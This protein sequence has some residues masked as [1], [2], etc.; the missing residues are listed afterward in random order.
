MQDKTSICILCLKILFNKSIT[1][2]IE[3]LPI[4]TPR[5]Y[6]SIPINLSSTECSIQNAPRVSLLQ[7]SGVPATFRIDFFLMQSLTLL[8]RFA[9]NWRMSFLQSQSCSFKSIDVSSNSR[10]SICYCRLTSTE[11]TALPTKRQRTI[12]N[13]KKIESEIEDL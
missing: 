13:Y 1:N 9:S 5:R 12:R 2:N 8:T 10:W 6:G 4:A 3:Q 11:V 7:P